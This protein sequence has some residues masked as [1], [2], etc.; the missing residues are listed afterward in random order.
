MSTH[1]SGSHVLAECVG[2]SLIDHGG[3]CLAYVVCVSP[4]ADTFI[5]RR[6][7]WSSR[8]VW[9]KEFNDK[10]KYKTTIQLIRIQSTIQ[11]LTRPSWPLSLTPRNRQFNRCLPPPS[12]SFNLQRSILTFYNSN[13]R[14]SQKTTGKS[15]SFPEPTSRLILI[16]I[17]SCFKRYT[18]VLHHST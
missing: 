11:L 18:Q 13:N 4:G 17:S 8:F 14:N 16:P 10:C 5:Q 12:T 15:T 3:D 6:S 1:A 2:L 9:S 7:K